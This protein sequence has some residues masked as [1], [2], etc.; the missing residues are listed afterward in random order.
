ML[1]P[2]REEVWYGGVLRA[3]RYDPEGR[4]RPE[5]AAWI[6]KSGRPLAARVAAPGDGVRVLGE[7]LEL[8]L[9]RGSAARLAQLAVEDPQLVAAL[10]GRTVL[11]IRHQPHWGFQ[12]GVED[13]QALLHGVG[14]EQGYV[15][16]DVSL[17]LTRDMF[18]T[19]HEFLELDLVQPSRPRLCAVTVPGVGRRTVFIGVEPAYLG[20]GVRVFR[21]LNAYRTYM[22]VNVQLDWEW[23]VGDDASILGLETR[24]LRWLN[25][26]QRSDIER[27]LL[28]L[29]PEGHAACVIA[30][31]RDDVDRPYDAA[32]VR[33]LI[34]VT[35]ALCDAFAARGAR[36]HKAHDSR[37]EVWL[38]HPD[39]TEAD[40][41]LAA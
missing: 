13:S 7:L 32:D 16:R 33:A 41:A 5:I 26:N 20:N 8:L 27:Y 6:L 36:R 4:Y 2:R 37:A 1:D 9:Q 21:D 28:P 14:Y 30:T 38:Q 12:I 22:H 17:E 18:A 23:D 19:W 11:P 35:R 40:F 10:R 25:A 3:R 34:S 31:D 15:A 39:A 24:A 29:Q